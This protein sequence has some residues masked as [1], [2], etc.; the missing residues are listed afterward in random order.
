MM[1][2]TEIRLPEQMNLTFGQGQSRLSMNDSTQQESRTADGDNQK[3]MKSAGSTRPVVELPNES[4]EDSQGPG[5]VLFNFSGREPAW[6]S[7]NDTVMGGISSSAV[8]IDSKFKR[9]TFS[10]NVSLENNGGFAS[11]RSQWAPYNLEAFD[12]IAMRV[13]G[14]GNQYRLRIRTQTT[15]V[16]IAYT[17]LFSTAKDQWQEVYIPFSEML[18]LYRGHVVHAA[19]PIDPADVRSFG[20]MVADK[21]QGQFSLAVQWINAVAEKKA[22]IQVAEL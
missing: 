15:G 22:E 18:P 9:L 14:D 21:Q 11:I 6:M 4:E 17:A 2:Q 3:Q 8:E 12:G 16:D 10:G 19:G 1:K 20:L 5:M 7:V 13:R